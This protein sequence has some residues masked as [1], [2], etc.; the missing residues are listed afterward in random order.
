MTVPF[1]SH[2][3]LE[4]RSIRHGF[5]GREGGVSEGIYESLNAGTGSRDEVNAVHENRS[6]IAHALGLSGPEPLVS[7]F[8]VHGAEAVHVTEPFDR[9]PQAD[10]MVTDRPGLGLCILTAD[11]GPVL[12]ADVEAGVIGAAHA[13]WRGAVAGILESTLLAME[14]LGA[15]IERISAVV[16][17]CIALD[18]YEVGLDFRDDLLRHSP[19][20]EAMFRDGPKGRPHFDLRTYIA[21]RLQAAGTGRVEV[22]PEDTYAMGATY[23]SHR[24]NTH[25]GLSDY[26]R[27]ASVIVLGTESE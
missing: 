25:E 18:T 26:G 14:G 4:S 12:L 3:A 11:C 2:A 10:A 9:R 15:R 19:W 22:M 24:R 6:R 27:N 8:Q 13:G 1:L 23:H 5:F 7:V 16:G 17:P 21:A 20:A